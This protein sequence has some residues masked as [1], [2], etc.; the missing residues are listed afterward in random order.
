MKIFN[1]IILT[2]ILVINILFCATMIRIH[3]SIS[4]INNEFQTIK[5]DFYKVIGQWPIN[6]KK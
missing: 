1:A 6:F 4:L 3:N 2:L 5:T